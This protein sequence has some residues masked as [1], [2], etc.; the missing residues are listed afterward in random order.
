MAHLT[1]PALLLVEETMT[2][3]TQALTLEPKLE[4]PSED[5][6]HALQLLDALETQLDPVMIPPGLFEPDPVRTIEARLERARERLELLRVIE[7]RLVSAVEKLR[8]ARASRS[9]HIPCSA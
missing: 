9:G 6:R 4:I 2:T 3:P 5:V 1:T 8:P 7:A